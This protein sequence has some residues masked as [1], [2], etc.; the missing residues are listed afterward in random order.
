[1]PRWQVA[2]IQTEAMKGVKYLKSGKIRRYYS[3]VTFLEEKSV[4]LRD[5]LEQSKSL[6]H[7]PICG[8]MLTAFWWYVLT[9]FVRDIWR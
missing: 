7:H 3:P 6:Q 2:L 1:M 9:Q 4:K 8:L 5:I